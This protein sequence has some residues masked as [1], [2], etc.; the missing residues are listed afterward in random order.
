MRNAQKLIKAFALVLATL[1]IVG[2]F[3]AIIG[4]VS[5][6]AAVTGAEIGGWVSDSSAWTSESYA[7]TAI[8]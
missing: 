8:L 3:T 7:K 2:I 6:L 5:F 4:G 1:I